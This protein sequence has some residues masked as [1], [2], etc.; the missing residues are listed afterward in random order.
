MT[1]ATEPQIDQFHIQQEVTI[2][3]T[4]ERVFKALT[5]EI[6]KWWF[7]GTIP[8]STMR[9]E[10][11]IGGMMFEDTGNGTGVW[12][13]TVVDWFPGKKLCIIGPVG[14][15]KPCQSVVT[16]ELEASG[17]NTIL[18]FRHRGAGLM[19][20]NYGADYDGGWKELFASLK[21]HIEG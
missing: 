11:K 20:A 18:K 7:E 21:K 9:I 14:V 3:A 6:D 2:G 5:S 15:R 17:S 1:T 4:P 13:G 16:F 12:W 8:N 19:D 10:P